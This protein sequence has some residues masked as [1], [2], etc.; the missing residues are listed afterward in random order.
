MFLKIIFLIYIGTII[1]T[2]QSIGLTM[3]EGLKPFYNGLLRPFA[4][5]LSRLGVYP[6]HLTLLGLCLFV[7][8]GWM[9]G[10]GK[11]VWALFMVI[12]GSL[13]DGL[14]GVVARESGKKTVFGAILDSSCDRLTEIFL[15][16]GILV[17]YL[18]TPQIN[19]PG[20]VACFTGI[21]G[22][23]MVSYVKA[24]CEGAGVACKRGLLQRPERLILLSIGLLAGPQTMIWIL[25]GI[26][27]LATFTVIQR[28][29]EA[30]TVCR[31]TDGTEHNS[32]VEP[33]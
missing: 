9:S 14:D 28:L 16:L 2:S 25:L 33:R 6:N 10:R 7:T 17:Y 30:A 18:K 11:W 12:A 20:V 21:C 24:R 3:L 13:M 15:I 1:K 22:S 26:S 4:R 27:A 31:H 29:F 5:F 32:S 23:V 19:I 8:A